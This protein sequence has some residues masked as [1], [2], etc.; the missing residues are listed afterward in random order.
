MG[1]PGRRRPLQ[2]A[3]SPEEWYTLFDGEGRLVQEGALRERVFYSG[4]EPGLRRWA[5]GTGGSAAV[6]A[7]RAVSR[8]CAGEGWAALAGLQCWLCM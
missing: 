1:A 2:P 3:L 4:C 5:L 6:L 8:G 7:V